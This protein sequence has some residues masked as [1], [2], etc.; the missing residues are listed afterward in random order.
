MI[1]GDIC[2]S[3]SRCEGSFTADHAR[4]LSHVHV[5]AKTQTVLRVKQFIHFSKRQMEII[6][7]R[8]PIMTSTGQFRLIV[9]MRMKTY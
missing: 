4:S 8:F 2:R 9:Q 5:H 6:I 7:G 1:S 3:L